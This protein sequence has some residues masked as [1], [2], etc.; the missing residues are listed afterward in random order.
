MIA[1]LLAVGCAPPPVTGSVEMPIVKV[2]ELATTDLDAVI[3]SDALP[4]A[5]GSI[6][7]LDGYHGRILRFD[8]TGHALG[9]WSDSPRLGHPVRLAAAKDGGVLAVDPGGDEEPGAILHLDLKGT[10]DKAW[11]PTDA[12]D[13]PLHPVDVIDLGAQLVVADRAAGILWLDGVDGK[14]TKSVQAGLKDEALRRVVDLVAL[15]GG[16]FDA[17]DTFT[18]RVHTF[19][20]DGAPTAAFG[21]VGLSAGRLSRPKAAA[22]TAEGPVFVA[23][24]VL[25]AVQVFE[26]DGDLI[27]VLSTGSGALKLEHPTTVRI[28]QDDPRHIVVVEARPAKLRVLGLE[29]PLPAAPPASLVRTEL[30]EPT[31]EVTIDKGETCLQCHDGLVRAG[32]EVWDPASGHHPVDIKPERELPAFFPLDDEGKIQCGTCHSPHGAVTR[33][34]ALSASEPAPKLLRHQSS[35]SAFLRLDKETDDLCVA[36][37]KDDAH[38]G[39]GTTVVAGKAGH[40]TGAALIAALKKRA[41]SAGSPTTGNCLS[42]HAMH[43]ASGVKIT[44]DP[45][46]GATCLAC[47]EDKGKRETNHALGR[48]P[49]KDLER[50]NRGQ[51][52]VLARDGGI[53]CLSCHDPVNGT[54]AT[55]LRVVSRSGPVCLDCHAERTDLKKGPH[56]GLAK[57]GSP[58]C[59][60]CHDVHGGDRDQHMLTIVENASAKDPDGCL[61]CHGPGGRAAKA[62]VAPGSKGHPVDAR[63]LDNGGTLT[64]LSCHEAHS[65]S[66]PTPK[67]CGACHKEQGEAFARGG[68]G[69]ATCNDCHAPHQDQRFARA[70]ENPAAARC[71]SCHA[72]GT[73]DGRAPKVAAWHHPTPNFLPDGGR[74][75]PLASLLLVGMDGKPVAPGANG[76]L[77]CASCHVTHGPDPKGAD[78]LRKANGWQ[79][80][81]AACHGDDALLM[82]KY[83]HFPERREGLKGGAQ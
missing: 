45:G 57:A 83:F 39:G 1:L 63:K 18:A 5:D 53:G 40:P 82:Y 44:R 59:V 50:G 46:E 71:L 2:Q 29:G 15:P 56:A 48:V 31:A 72:P 25:D 12:D 22:A 66:A 4:M 11:L 41:P 65:A 23:D 34:E 67:E 38:A 79:E 16:G 74:W 20:A 33:E 13:K 28:A 73:A 24:S 76:E 75:K 7:V 37:H 43:G 69:R 49:G 42:C 21:K 81:C 6:L 62:S 68:H 27:G 60:A 77:S 32:Q 52:L 51:R 35:G 10:I 47:H 8:G 30:A 3:P 9:V 64:C 58:A 26:P 55:L 80:A 61:T 70:G 54:G 36:C 19:G 17:V 14:A 78:K